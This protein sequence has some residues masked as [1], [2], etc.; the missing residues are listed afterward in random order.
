MSTAKGY[1]ASILQDLQDR[2][3]WV[4]LAAC[5]D[6][7][8]EILTLAGEV[9]GLRDRL[10]KLQDERDTL[11]AKWQSARGSLETLQQSING[12]CERL[13]IGVVRS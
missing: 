5:F 6:A 2:R 4:R 9:G 12:K 11:S 8:A 7:R 13:K 10:S 1:Q 3:A